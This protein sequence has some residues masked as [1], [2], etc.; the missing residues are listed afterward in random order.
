MEITYSSLVKWEELE[1]NKDVKNKN[2]LLSLFFNNSSNVNLKNISDDILKNEIDE[3]YKENSN[4]YEYYLNH[5]TN[6]YYTDVWKSIYG[7]ATDSMIKALSIVADRMSEI[8]KTMLPIEDIG[9]AIAN[10]WKKIPWDSV[11]DDQIV[12]WST[13]GWCFGPFIE[14]SELSNVPKT[15]EEADSRLL[16]YYD[17]SKIDELLSLFKK[18]YSNLIV[19]DELFRCLNLELYEACVM[20]LYSKISYLLFEIGNKFVD[21]NR[22]RTKKNN[23]KIVL[24]EKVTINDFNENKINYSSVKKITELTKYKMLMMCLNL[25]FKNGGGFKKQPLV[26][27]RNFVLHGMYK[28]K[29]TKTHCIKLLVCLYDLCEFVDFYQSRK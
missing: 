18:N 6:D 10:A 12:P 7:P 27:N 8:S 23:N 26:P 20:L 14:Y 19:V 21:I 16:K 28:G 2:K 11:I 25:Y 4:N 3:F 15:I 24:T 5:R 9:N 13:Y 17:D 22:L 29:I 1:A